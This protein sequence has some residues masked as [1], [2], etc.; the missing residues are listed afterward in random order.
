MAQSWLLNSQIAEDIL[1][2]RFASDLKLS[3]QGFSA[4]VQ[5]EGDPPTTWK[6]GLSPHKLA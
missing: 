1:R 5:T 3:I 2:V 6:F 4:W